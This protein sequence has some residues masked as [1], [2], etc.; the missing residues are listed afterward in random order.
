[1]RK[2]KLLM[3]IVVTPILASVA[4]PLTV[5]SC[6]NITINKIAI[7][8]MPSTEF[9]LNDKF[10]Y[11]G[12]VVTATYSDNTSKE[13]TSHCTFSQPNMSTVGEKEVVVTHVDSSKTTTY[14]INVKDPSTPPEHRVTV[15]F[16]IND[17]SGKSFTQQ[18]VP[19]KKATKP[20]KPIGSNNLDFVAWYTQDDSGGTWDETKRYN[21]DTILLQD[22]QLYARWAGDF[23]GVNWLDVS[24]AIDVFEAIAEPTA[25]NAVTLCKALGVSTPTEESSAQTTL[26]TNLVSLTGHIVMNGQVHTIR[27]ID[28]MHDTITNSTT[29]AALTFELVTLLS[30]ANGKYM[31][32]RWSNTNNTDY[33]NSTLR[34][35]LNKTGSGTIAWRQ[36]IDSEEMVLSETKSAFEMIQDGSSNLANAIK[37]VTKSVATKSSTTYDVTSYDDKLFTL[38]YTEMAQSGSAYAKEEGTSYKYWA[39]NE[40]LPEEEEQQKRNARKKQDII[41]TEGLPDAPTGGFAYWLATP[42]T[43]NDG[44]SH[45]VNAFGVISSSAASKITTLNGTSFAFC[46]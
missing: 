3:P 2:S 5:C 13:V 17:G 38:T 36:K 46:I 15:T 4:V 11:E 24:K 14:K 26:Q 8:I 44:S 29:K 23:N 28:A 41:K 39:D 22:Q 42:Q 30:D 31:G 25:A 6:S 18:I 1:M 7:T 32:C 27:C 19:G 9:N 40:A 34:A 20:D 12:I 45:I 35:N 43:R 16:H 10:S 37:S 21:F 33:L